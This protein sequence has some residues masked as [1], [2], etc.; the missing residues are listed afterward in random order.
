MLEDVTK[1]FFRQAIYAGSR[2]RLSRAEPS[3]FQLAA[4]NN[5]L[6]FD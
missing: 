6:V 3:Y 5:T 4:S 1:N 2:H